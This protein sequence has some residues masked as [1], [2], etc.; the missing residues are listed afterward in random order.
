MDTGMNMK[1][2]EDCTSYLMVCVKL[3]TKKITRYKRVRG[4]NLKNHCEELL[5]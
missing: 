5:H 2:C 1:V 3:Y 4:W